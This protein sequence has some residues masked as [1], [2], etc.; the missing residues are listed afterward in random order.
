MRSIFVLIFLALLTGISF[1]QT[2]KG[3]VV[4]YE[5]DTLRGFVDYINS[6]GAFRSA[7]KLTYTSD[8]GKDKTSKYSAFKIKSFKCGDDFIEAINWE[9]VK[10][11]I[12]GEMYLYSRLEME[13]FE[14]DSWLALN[15]FFRR[16]DETHLQPANVV[17]NS[18][19]YK[20]FKDNPELVR[21]LK[22]KEI[23]KNDPITMVKFYNKT[24]KTE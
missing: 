15:Y 21:K 16:K 18:K 7:V 13:Y 2:G 12:E 8:K 20:Y 4:T 9:F 6:D 17:F 23:F 14:G 11:E 5:N 22:E 19:L 10:K 1:A 24:H 3:Y